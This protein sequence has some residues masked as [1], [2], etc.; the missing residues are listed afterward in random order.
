[1]LQ[2]T[3]V[4]PLGTDF[5]VEE[6]N[7][8]LTFYA[9]VTRQDKNEW[10]AEG[11]QPQER[12]TREETLKGMTIW[13]AYANFEDHEKGSIEEGK[14]ADFVIFEKDIMQVEASEILDLAPKQVYINGIL[15]Q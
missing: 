6:V 15:Q 1:M 10:P 5:P 4:L 14:F 12:L 8:L 2:Q 9:A 3:G 7:P 11:F 13:A